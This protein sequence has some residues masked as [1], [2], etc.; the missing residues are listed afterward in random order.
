M[1]LSLRRIISAC[2]TLSLLLI[3]NCYAASAPPLIDTLGSAMDQTEV[4]FSPDLRQFA[5][6]VLV[7]FVHENRVVESRPAARAPGVVLDLHLVRTSLEV[8]IRG[9]LNSREVEFYY[10]VQSPQSPQPNARYKRLFEAEQGRRYIFFLCEENGVLRSVG[11][12]GEYSVPVLSGTHS[13]YHPDASNPGD[14]VADIL[15]TL[16]SGASPEAFARSLRSSS[17]VSDAWGSR[18]HTVRLLRKLLTNA[19]PIRE[20]AC[21]VLTTRYNGQHDCEYGVD[22]SG[23]RE[24]SSFRAYLQD[25]RDARLLAA[26]RSTGSLDLPIIGTPDSRKRMRE[27]LQ[28][29]AGSENPALRGASCAVLAKYYPGEVIPECRTGSH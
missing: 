13:G 22:R 9:R 23:Q 25:A 4:V 8:P 2:G 14:T 15:L 11:D 19:G 10:F 7:G 18:P 17:I 5:P 26:L 12:V 3:S 16:G 24:E 21:I 6:I 29:I 27:E 1:R 28:S 20:S